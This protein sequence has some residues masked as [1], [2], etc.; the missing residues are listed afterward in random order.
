MVL[1]TGTMAN[2]LTTK[3]SVTLREIFLNEIKIKLLNYYMK[4]KHI[5]L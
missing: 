3:V 2:P 4:G 1:E 5:R